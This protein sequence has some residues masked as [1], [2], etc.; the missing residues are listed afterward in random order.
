MQLQRQESASDSHLEVFRGVDKEQDNSDS[1]HRSTVADRS[2]PESSL[3][4]ATRDSW[5]VPNGPNFLYKQMV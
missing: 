5:Y 4:F 1:D 2:E 3:E